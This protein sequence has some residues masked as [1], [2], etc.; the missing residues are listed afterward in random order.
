MIIQTQVFSNA[1]KTTE[2]VIYATS[3]SFQIVARTA[4]IDRRILAEVS[5]EPTSPAAIAS[6]YKYARAKAQALLEQ[7]CTDKAVA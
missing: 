1:S 7:L 5:F 3:S 6:A 2:T 4:G